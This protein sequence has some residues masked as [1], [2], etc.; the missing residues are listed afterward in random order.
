VTT[1][2]GSARP[3]TACSVKCGAVYTGA[4]SDSAIV[5]VRS[6]PRAATKAVA[7]ASTTGTA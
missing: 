4:A 6:S 1:N 5:S 2:S 7:T 3:I